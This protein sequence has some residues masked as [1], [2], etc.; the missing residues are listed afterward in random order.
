MV[1]HAPFFICVYFLSPSEQI[2]I[3]FQKL[4]QQSNPLLHYIL[5]YEHSVLRGGGLRECS[6][7]LALLLPCPSVSV[8]SFLSVPTE[9]CNYRWMPSYSPL[10]TPLRLSCGWVARLW[11]WFCCACIKHLR[12]HMNNLN[13]VFL[14]LLLLQITQSDIFYMA[15]I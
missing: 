8:S 5:C 10:S 2:T 15:R 14:L 4:A 1:G 12:I 13:P 7:F 9:P 11:M 3:A 6:S